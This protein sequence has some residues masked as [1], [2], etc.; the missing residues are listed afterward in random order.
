MDQKTIERV[1]QPA[2]VVAG[3]RADSG[4]RPHHPRR[5]HRRW[6]WVLGVPVVLLAAGFL[7]IVLTTSRAHEVTMAQAEQRLGGQGKGVA[8]ARPARGVYEYAGS[9]TDR[10]TLPPMSQSDGPTM[11]GTVT[12]SGRN[13]WVWRIDYSS[14]HW[15]TV[16]YCRHGD[17]TWETGGQIWQLWS[18]GP[19]RET[20]L[21]TMTCAPHTVSL[22]ATAVPGQVWHERCTGTSTAV[23]GAMVSAGPYRFLGPRALIVG[24]RVVR[25]D[26]FLRLRTDT[27]AQR[28]TERSE[29]WIDAAN[30]LPIRLRRDITVITDTPFGTSTYTQSSVFS[31]ASLVPRP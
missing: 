24:G 27:G 3:V 21:T 1:E 31:L 28:G 20:N 22:P 26:E 13:C 8:G 5:R 11:P 29:L 2:A 16:D 25:A 10:L 15:E 19:L 17:A 18:I 6:P 23:K 30:G 14:H 7:V 12:L 4:T 9:G